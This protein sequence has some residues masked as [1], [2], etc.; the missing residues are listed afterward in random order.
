VLRCLLQGTTRGSWA[1]LMVVGIPLLPRT[2]QFQPLL[3]VWS[4]DGFGYSL[5]WFWLLVV[6]GSY[7][8]KLPSFVGQC[9]VGYKLV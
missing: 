4:D 6:F 2:L 3:R 1:V 9:W 5:L 8:S 7:V